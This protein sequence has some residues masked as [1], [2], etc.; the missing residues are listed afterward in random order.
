MGRCKRLT[1]N[2]CHPDRY[3]EMGRDYS[4]WMSFLLIVM[5]I[6]SELLGGVED[7]FLQMVERLFFLG[8]ANENPA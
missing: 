6:V 5:V 8:N 3:R 2:H 1:I 7:L 4:G